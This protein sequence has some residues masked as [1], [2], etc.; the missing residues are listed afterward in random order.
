V[1]VVELRGARVAPGAADA[2]QVSLRER[3]RHAGARAAEGAPLGGEANLAPGPAA[4]AVDPGAPAPT[5]AILPW[6]DVFT[7]W[8][9]RLDVPLAAFVDGFTGSWMFGYVDALAEA[10]VRSLIVCVTRRVG[11]PVHATHRPSGASLVFLPAAALARP[12]WGRRLERHVTP[13]LATPPLALARLLRRHGCSAVLCQEYETPR[14]DVAVA[15]GRML[16]IPVCATFQG[17]DY[18]LSRLERFVRPLTIGRARALIA[19][20]GREAERVRSRYGLVVA[21]VFNPVD[22]DAWRPGDRAAA[23]ARLGIPP[24]AR[25]V[26]WHGQLQI[27]RKGLDV[28]L[29]AWAELRR[30][31]PGADLRLFLAG[32]GEDA[33]ALRSRL[34]EPSLAGVEL[35]DRWL[36]R[37]DLAQ[38]L[39]AADVYAFPSRH[40]GFAIAPVEAMA[41]GL[42][43]VAA[44]G[45]GMSDL[46]AEPEEH[47]GVVVPAADSGALA[48]ALRAL[49]EDEA[50]RA[51]LG[52]RA[53]ARAVS[54]CSLAAV[55]HRLRSI[56]VDGEL[57]EAAA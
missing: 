32:A 25:V 56:V 34:A 19:A 16:R 46:L 11:A 41:C 36:G 1:E 57:P 14:F 8:L 51:A 5:V 6:G 21:R 18:Q 20:S 4:T 49:L 13:Y 35:L 29:A 28:L 27:E 22:V 15:V 54:E 37:D 31:L 33:D 40:E 38:L 23:R 53:R 9:D 44:E 45:S 17:G 10:G 42:P 43:V 7:D 24:R 47:G 3:T 26:A 12:T 2:E 52:G 30:D 50:R 48:R 39:S 55:G